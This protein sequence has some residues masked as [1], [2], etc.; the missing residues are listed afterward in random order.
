VEV[1]ALIRD[2]AIIIL[3]LVFILAGIASLLVLW[4]VW[5]LIGFVRGTVEQLS[6]RATDVLVTARGVVGT[7][8]QA[9]RTARGTVDFVSDLVVRPVIDVASAV[10]AAS[11]FTR[12]LFRPRRAVSAKREGEESP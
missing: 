3:A 11:A 10:A 2:L 12:A 1:I 8:Q 7:A 4:Q 9:A 5:K 6:V